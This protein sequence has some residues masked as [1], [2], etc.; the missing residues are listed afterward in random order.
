MLS[1]ISTSLFTQ[2]DNFLP[3]M[4]ITVSSLAQASSFSSFGSYIQ[5]FPIPGGNLG[6]KQDIWPL[7]TSP[8]DELFNYE[9]CFTT[10]KC[11]NIFLIS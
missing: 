9:L 1:P 11:F 7:R 2:T 3:V 4:I 8:T 6:V 10:Y 5:S